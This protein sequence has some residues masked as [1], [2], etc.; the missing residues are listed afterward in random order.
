M[1]SAGVI[2]TAYELLSVT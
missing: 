2:G 1:K